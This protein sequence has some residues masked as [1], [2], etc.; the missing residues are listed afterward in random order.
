MEGRETEQA[1]PSQDMIQSTATIQGKHAVVRLTQLAWLAGLIDGEGSI[2]ANKPR[3]QKSAR[4]TFA[5]MMTCSKT[6]RVVRDLICQLIG[7]KCK[8]RTHQPHSKN[9]IAKLA[10]GI[11]ITSHAKVLEFLE[12]IQPFLITKREVVECSLPILRRKKGR[13]IPRPDWEEEL[14]LRM[15]ELNRRGR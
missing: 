8:I 12:L 11:S 14:Y 3:D 13:W 15:R 1:D 6:V 4:I 5:L 2:W 9:D 10:Y 7:Y